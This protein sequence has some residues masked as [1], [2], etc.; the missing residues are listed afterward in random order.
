MLN[1]IEK[2]KEYIYKFIKTNPRYLGNEDL[3]EDFCNEAYLK[4]NLFL[5]AVNNAS[6][7]EGYIRKVVNTSILNVLKNSG[8]IRR[9]KNG[10]EQV[11][12]V[13]LDL[14]VKESYS[15]KNKACNQEFYHQTNVSIDN[16]NQEVI[17]NKIDTSLELEKIVD[18]IIKLNEEDP[19]KKYL[20][21]FSLRFIKQAKQKE[22]SK[23]LKIS[24][25]EVSKR[26]VKMSDL[27]RKYLSD[28]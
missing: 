3:L 14:E 27:I 28:F 17:D 6:N 19:T 22:I 5:S 26:L 18:F 2:Q 12:S 20:E 15:I 23:N 25:S 4:L 13:P 21:L 8:K 9:T 16:S 11:T 1:T 10:Y 24:Q 7:I